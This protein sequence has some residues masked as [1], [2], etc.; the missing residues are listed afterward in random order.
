VKRLE[1]KWMFFVVLSEGTAQDLL[2]LL[3]SFF[4]RCR[5]E[6]TKRA[7]VLMSSL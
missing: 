7:I 2:V 3:F 5:W 6:G 1:N 4:L